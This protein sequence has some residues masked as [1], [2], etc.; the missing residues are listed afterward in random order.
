[1]KLLDFFILFFLIFKKE[2]NKTSMSVGKWVVEMWTEEKNK[3][4]PDLENEHVV[5]KTFFFFVSCAIFS[6]TKKPL[7]FLVT[8]VCYLFTLASQLLVCTSLFMRLFLNVD[9]VYI[10]YIVKFF[11]PKHFFVLGGG[12]FTSIAQVMRWKCRDWV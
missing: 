5:K 4:S 3:W 1:M 7:S 11:S 8:T 10:L 6:L 12:G 2:K 9:Q